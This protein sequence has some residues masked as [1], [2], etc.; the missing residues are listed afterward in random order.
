MTNSFENR[1][2]LKTTERMKYSKIKSKNG[3]SE[4]YDSEYKNMMLKLKFDHLN[5]SHLGQHIKAK[6][7]FQC[8]NRNIPKSDWSEFINHELLNPKKYIKISNTKEL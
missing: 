4:N 6:T 5:E 1:N 2:K 8:L 7:L 3:K